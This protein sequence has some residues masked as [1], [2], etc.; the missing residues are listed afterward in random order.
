MPTLYLQMRDG[1]LEPSSPPAVEGG[2]NPYVE[3][4]GELKQKNVPS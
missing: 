2:V 4:L 3:A 1:I